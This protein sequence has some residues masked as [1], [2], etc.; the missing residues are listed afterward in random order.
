MQ[1]KTT[2][3]LI[4]SFYRLNFIHYLIRKINKYLLCRNQNFFRNVRY[5]IL[6]PR[7]LRRTGII[8]SGNSKTVSPP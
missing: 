2:R 8:G 7:S 6:G 3:F 1:M 5:K 4:Y